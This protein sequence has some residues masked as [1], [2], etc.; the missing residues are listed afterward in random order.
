MWTASNTETFLWDAYCGS[1]LTSI[2]LAL[3]DIIIK[4]FSIKRRKTKQNITVHF[5]CANLFNRD[6]ILQCLHKFCK[7]PD[8]YMV[9]LKELTADLLV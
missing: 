1:S 4:I 5:G 2:T 6:K 7:L 3:E 9:K 8:L